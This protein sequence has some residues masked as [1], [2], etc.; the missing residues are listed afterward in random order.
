MKSL[1]IIATLLFLTSCDVFETRNAEAPDQSR[2]NYQPASEP[3]IVI[4]NLINAFADK[5]GDNYLKSFSEGA[6]SN[7]IFTFLPSSS[8]LSRFQNVWPNWNRDAELQYFNNMKTSVP[9]ELPVTLTFSNSSTSVFGDSLKYTAQYFLNVPQR[10]T[11]PLIFEGN[12][13]FNMERDSRSV[14]VIYLWK[15]NA[16]EDKP[17]WS[18]LKGSVY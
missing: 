12:V 16:I 18:D 6:F 17:S 14:W 1:L 4:Q 10:T 8:A 9:D 5:N 15:D 3:E 13:E 7:K 2:S 11:D